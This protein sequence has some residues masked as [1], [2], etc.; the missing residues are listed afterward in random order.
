MAQQLKTDNEK[1]TTVRLYLNY[2]SLSIS[3][4]GGENKKWVH[5]CFDVKTLTLI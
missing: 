2:Y 3:L 1:S 5:N 4:T